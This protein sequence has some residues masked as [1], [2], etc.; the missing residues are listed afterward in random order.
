MLMKKENSIL[1]LAFLFLVLS[2]NSSA[3]AFCAHGNENTHIK[4]TTPS[5][6]FTDNGDGTVTHHITG[7]VWQ[8]CSLG[9]IWD[10]SNCSGDATTYTWEQALGA[11]ELNDFINL[12]DWRLPNRNELISIVEYRCYDPTINNQLF[13]STP[14][15]W[16]WSSSPYSSDNNDARDFHFGDGTIHGNG[17]HTHS[18]VRL[19][20]DIK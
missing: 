14:P 20:R 12:S 18:Y 8:R 7:L 16:Y 11:A 4:A 3:N 1:S 13:P 6:E 15:S 5:E 2:S 9:Q 17:R 19:V 10:V